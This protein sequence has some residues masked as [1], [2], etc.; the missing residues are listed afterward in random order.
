MN[1]NF[2]HAMFPVFEAAVTY[3]TPNGDIRTD[4]KLIVRKDTN[5]ILSCM[6]NEYKVVKNETI[7][8]Y[9]LPVIQ[10]AG[11]MFK[12][13]KTFAEGA[14]TTMTW[15]FPNEQ[16]TIG[17]NDVLTPEI[18]IKN[19]YDG[20]IGVNVLAGAFRLVCTNG[21]II[22]VVAHDYRNKHSVYN[23]KLNDIEGIIIETIAKTKATFKDEFPI[24]QNTEIK[25]KHIVDFLKMFPIKANSVVTQRLIADRPKTF[26][27]LFNVGTN[28]TTHHMDRN[29]E[30]THK[31]ENMLYERV[32]KMALSENKAVA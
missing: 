25:E 24:L 3:D 8:K 4:Y 30:S 10:D 31:L 18:I 28:V 7:I 16:V 29:T 23:V 27:D 14:R 2:E 26:W 13:C 11:G 9:A 21:M 6:T 22:G 15:N 1:S 20:T 12:E 32:K 17:K 5:K 19:S